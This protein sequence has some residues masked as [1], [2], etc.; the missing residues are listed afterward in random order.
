[1]I[2]PSI[3]LHIQASHYEAMIDHAQQSPDVEVC[4]LLG[5]VVEGNIWQTTGCYPA[6]N[7]APHPATTYT[8]DPVE[9]VEVFYKLQQQGQ[10]LIGIY[11]SHPHGPAHPSPTDI[12]QATYPDVA[13]LILYREADGTFRG[14]AWRIFD[15]NTHAMS[16]GIIG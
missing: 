7:V 13:Y 12:A 3:T 10:R 9:L 14:A 4:G 6:M 16:I 15:G 11:H 8:L 2:V 1:M 5:G